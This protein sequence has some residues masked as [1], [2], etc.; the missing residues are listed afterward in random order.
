MIRASWLLIEQ[1]IEEVGLLAFLQL[2]KN[3]VSV[4][5]KFKT[6]QHNSLDDLGDSKLF[7]SHVSRVMNVMRKVRSNMYVMQWMNEWQQ[8]QHKIA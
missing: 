7:Q 3:N 2:F 4:Q 8:K 6:F 1:H 5:D